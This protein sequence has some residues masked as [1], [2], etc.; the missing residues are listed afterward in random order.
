LPPWDLLNR[1]LKGCFYSYVTVI[2]SWKQTKS[3]Y[4]IFSTSRQHCDDRH[5]ETDIAPTESAVLKNLVRPPF[6]FYFMAILQFNI[7]FEFR[8]GLRNSNSNKNEISKTLRNKKFGHC[9][10]DFD[11]LEFLIGNLL[12]QIS[13][14]L[15]HC[16]LRQLFVFFLFLIV[17]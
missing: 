1:S 2:I 5:F 11:V 8:I 3:V 10:K 14:K 17:E 12:F 15:T 4:F 16:I 7:S 13:V 9:S 6:R